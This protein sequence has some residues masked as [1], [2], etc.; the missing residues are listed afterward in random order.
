LKVLSRTIPPAIRGIFFLSGSQNEDESVNN[1]QSI[2][3][4]SKKVTYAPWKL[5]FAYGKSIQ[6]S[7]IMTWKGKF[8]NVGKAQKEFLDKCRTNN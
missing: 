2:T 3:K 5:S 4:L 1:I 8:E 7:A 6:H